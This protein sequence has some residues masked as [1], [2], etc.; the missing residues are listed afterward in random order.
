MVPE[1]PPTDRAT[2]HVRRRR[3]LSSLTLIGFEEGAIAGACRHEIGNV[4]ELEAT[5]SED[6]VGVVALGDQIDAQAMH[7]VRNQDIFQHVQIVF[8]RVETHHDHFGAVPMQ[9]GQQWFPFFSVNDSLLR[10][11]PLAKLSVVVQPTGD[12]LDG[13]TRDHL[14]LLGRRRR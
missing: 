12:R 6:Q 13:K 9:I 2:S 10:Q 4:H 14:P 11:E 7:Q 1:V 5:S 8:A 3:T